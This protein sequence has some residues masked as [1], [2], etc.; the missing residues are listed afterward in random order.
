MS[1]TGSLRRW[2]EK[3]GAWS[4]SRRRRPQALDACR[5]PQVQGGRPG[6]PPCAGMTGDQI[7]CSTDGPTACGSAASA[8]SPSIDRATASATSM[9]STPADM[10]PPA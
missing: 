6:F 4:S 3:A 9:P 7:A 1:L 2:E 5:A 8:G 10:I